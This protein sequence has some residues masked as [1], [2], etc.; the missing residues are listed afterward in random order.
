MAKNPRLARKM[1]TKTGL[2]IVVDFVASQRSSR[3][4]A[5]AKKKA[6]EEVKLKAEEQEKGRIEG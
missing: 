2:C 5:E 1:A 3:A 6:E 4:K